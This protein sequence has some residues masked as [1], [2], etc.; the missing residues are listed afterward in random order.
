MQLLFATAFSA[1]S[2]SDLQ[3]VSVVRITD[4][5]QRKRIISSNPK[6]AWTEHA[7]Q[8]MVWCADNR[9]IRKV[10][11]E[12]DYP[13]ANDHLDSF[14][15]AAVDAGIVMQTFIIAA[16]S[17]GL[18]CCPISEV[19]D[20][21]ESLSMELNLPEHVFPVAG[22]CV[23]W[24]SESPSTSMRLPLNITVHVNKYDDE[25]A[26]FRI[27][28]YDHRR[29]AIDQPPTEKQRQPERFGI[30]D[31]YGW[32]EDRARQYSVPLRSGFGCYIR[33]QRFNLC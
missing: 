13:F 1:P 9:R 23:G 21:I 19:R 27:S 2:K 26:L 32:S 7:P 6:I 31:I 4:P 14:M 10:C 29:E 16:D 30:A 20:N 22:L 5:S 8:F 3:Q 24:P 12:K 11:E 18:R 15:N 17:V 28:D 33:K 25:E